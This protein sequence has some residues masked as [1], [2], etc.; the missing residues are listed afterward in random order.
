M[1]QFLDPEAVLGNVITSDC[2]GSLESNSGMSS[3]PD[4]EVPTIK[5]SSTGLGSA[6]RR[7]PGSKRKLTYSDDSDSDVGKSYAVEK[8][9]NGKSRSNVTNSRSNSDPTSQ[10]QNDRVLKELQRILLTL[11]KR[12]E[13]SEKRLK[14]VENKLES[15]VSSSADSTP[16]HKSKAKR[17]DVP[18]EVRVSLVNE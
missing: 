16:S 6:R 4:D 10:S 18:I 2:E 11:V 17:K 12:V 3:D 1:A 7:G 8:Q 15:G 5:H 13:N 9:K 14:I